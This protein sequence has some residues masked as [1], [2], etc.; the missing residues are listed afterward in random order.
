MKKISQNAKNAIIIGSTCS[1][2]YLA[3]YFARNV[4]GAASPGMIEGGGFTNESI[5]ALSSLFFITYAVGQLI[6]GFI[7]DKIKARN[8]ICLGLILAGIGNIFFALFPSNITVSYIS[9]AATGFFL[10]MIYGPMT[11]VVAENTEPIHAVRVSLGYTFS[12]FVGSPIAGVFAMVMAWQGV[13]YMSSLTLF[14]MAVIAFIV[15][16]RL[17]AKGVVKYNQYKPEKTEAGGGIKLLIKKDIIRFT[18]VSLLTGVIRTSVV[19]WLPT[20]IAQYLGFSA[21]SAALAFTVCSLIISANTFIAIFLYEKLGRKL[22][23]STC[24]FFALSAIS[25]AGVYFFNSPYVN[26]T[27]MVLAIIFA[28]CAA[29]MLWSVYCPGL[30]DTGMVSSATGFLDFISYMAASI[31]SS[32][33]ASSVTSIGW[34]GTIIIWFAI[35]LLGAIICIPFKKKAEN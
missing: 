27:F 9:Y 34:G 12:S 23:F 11:K 5:G 16:I 4:L 10:S 25:F 29:T 33:F 22:V 30:S 35:V 32:V 6:N 8:M 20:Y 18:F 26:I 31:S 13:F 19:F 15:F 1:L 14:I 17:E 24:L 3:V 21:E 2:S 7:G 28:N